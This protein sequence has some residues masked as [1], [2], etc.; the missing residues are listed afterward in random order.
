MRNK[1]N[2]IA[3]SIPGSLVLGFLLAYVH[4]WYYGNLPIGADLLKW[5]VTI[6]L[7]LFGYLLAGWFVT[8]PILALAIALIAI[9]YTK[10]SVAI[11][12]IGLL[13]IGAFIFG[14]SLWAGYGI[15][16]PW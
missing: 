2:L 9:G 14:A 7:C 10:E 15:R 11:S 1:K 16:H 5:F 4:L 13:I 8:L 12:A 3:A 6:P